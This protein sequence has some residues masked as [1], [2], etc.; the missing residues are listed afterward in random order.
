M[1]ALTVQPP[2]RVGKII[3]DLDGTLID[4]APDLHA[5]TNH[6]LETIGRPHI[7]L[8]QVRHMV[9]QGARR[10]IEKGLTA[11]G[12]RQNHSIDD[13]LPVFLE[14]YGNNLT[15]HGTSLFAGGADLLD[16]L[17]ATGF[18]LGLCT[19]KP[20]A[21]TKPLLSALKIDHHFGAVL[22]GD[23]LS[24][25]KPD[26]RHLIETADRLSG[27]TGAALMVGDSSSDIDA[28]KAAGWPSIAVTFGYSARPVQELGASHQ[29]DSLREIAGLVL[30]KTQP[31]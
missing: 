12:G 17:S 26:P 10:L 11:T 6:V 30:L 3:F 7:T 1:T 14:Y 4:S 24:V 5:A 25:R 28:A 9:G 31:V 22:G 20:V 15:R 27:S 29:V 19:N 8:G 13:L 2:F 16:T 21:L 18:G 23:S